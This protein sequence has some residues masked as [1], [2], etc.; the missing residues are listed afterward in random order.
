MLPQFRC[1][2]FAMTRP[3]GWPLGLERR[4]AQNQA[5]SLATA[6]VAAEMTAAI[7]GGVSFHDA[8]IAGLLHVP[9]RRPAS[10]G[11]SFRERTLPRR[12]GA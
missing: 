7:L 1:I 8:A 3:P 12:E 2:E 11:C 9:R 10:T 6:L 5:I 4:I